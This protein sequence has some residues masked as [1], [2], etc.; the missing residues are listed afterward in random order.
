MTFSDL[1]IQKGQLTDKGLT[2]VN[3][4]HGYINSFYSEEF[5]PKR[6]DNLK[7]V[8]IGIYNGDSLILFRDWFVNSHIIGIDNKT[9]M[10]D[11]NITKVDDIVEVDVVYKDA[12]D[13]ETLKSFEDESIDYLID[14][15]PHSIESQID[16]VELWFSK[17]K[18]GG[19]LI[20]EDIQ[21]IDIDKPKF[22][23]LGIPYEIIDTRNTSPTKRKD[24]VLLI[25]RK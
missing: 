9:E 7:I 6:Y 12:Y 11:A 22:D 21:D 23:K 1:Y 4:G 10:S 5:T 19:T 20:I 13:I 25:F 8:E 24:D 15:G 2:L 14:D 16:C 18:K 3:D 17:I